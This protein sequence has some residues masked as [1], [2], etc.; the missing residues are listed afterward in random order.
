MSPLHSIRAITHI[1]TR[2]SNGTASEMDPFIGG[3]IRRIMGDQALPNAWSECFTPVASLLELL[4]YPDPNRPVGIVVVT[5][6][7]NSF[8]HRLP[9]ELLQAAALDPRM[10]AGSERLTWTRPGY[11]PPTETASGRAATRPPSTT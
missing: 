9:E 2:N 11:P 10:A 5:D 6:H 4:R 1:H 3:T 8:S 7:M